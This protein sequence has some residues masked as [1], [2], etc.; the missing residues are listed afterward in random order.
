MLKPGLG[1]VFEHRKYCQCWAADEEQT[2]RKR[3]SIQTRSG[4]DTCFG[5]VTFLS[6]LVSLHVQ[7]RCET[8]APCTLIANNKLDEIL[9][10][11]VSWQ[12]MITVVT[13]FLI[14]IHWFYCLAI[15]I[16][17]QERR[18]HIFFHLFLHL[19]SLLTFLSTCLTEFN[20]NNQV[21]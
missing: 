3:K 14:L 6:P 5:N 11:T 18:F 4:R 1:R 17:I 19:T 21:K 2:E 15:L 16:N 9:L 10:G 7:N 8:A 12:W 20:L 13:V